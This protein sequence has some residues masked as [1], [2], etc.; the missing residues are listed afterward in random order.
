[1]LDRRDWQFLRKVGR[2]TIGDLV[3][4]QI[5]YY[6]FTLPDDFK[7]LVENQNTN[8]SSLYSFFIENR[9]YPIISLGESLN[10]IGE[11]YY[12][13][14]SKKAVLFTE[15]NLTGT[16]SFEYS[17]SPADIRLDTSPI[18]HKDY[19]PLLYHMMCVDHDIIDNTEAQFSN[20]NF[21]TG[22]ADSYREEMSTY[23]SRFE[24]NYQNI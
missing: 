24:G 19:H 4:I 3:Y 22:M 1:V 23:Y 11:N 2:S 20:I 15:R 9:E 21:H 17:H 18:F 10:Q 5:I 14:L 6:G 7:G 13:D 16:A 12:L 8:S